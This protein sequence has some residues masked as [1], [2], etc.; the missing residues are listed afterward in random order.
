ME[1]ERNSLRSPYVYC[2]LYANL[3]NISK[4]VKAVELAE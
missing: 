2:Y 4:L 1:L 3:K